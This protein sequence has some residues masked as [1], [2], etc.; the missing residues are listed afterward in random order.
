MTFKKTPL[1]QFIL[2]LC[3]FSGCIQKTTNEAGENEKYDGPAMIAQMEFDRTKD[4]ATGTVPR[5]RLMK[6]LAYTD[7]IKKMLPFQLIAGYGNWTERGPTSDVVGVSNGNTRANSGGNPSVASGRIRAV[8]VDAA[9][10]TGNTVFIGGVNGGI[11]KTTDITASPATWTFV[12]DFFSN[13]AITGICQDPVTPATMYFCTGEW[14]FNSDAVAG[15]GIFKSTNGGATW[16]QLGTTTGT[17]FDYCSKI[18]CDASGNVFVSSSRV[19]SL[20]KWRNKLGQPLRQV[21]DSNRFSDMELSS[22]GRLHVSYGVW[23]F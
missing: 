18:L 2:L 16:T 12:N 8:L 21:D 4:P 15:D 5:E 6:A 9:D 17:D 14:P 22:T 10:A 19:F 1:F 20:N 23:P 7:S 11:W 13:M 3:L